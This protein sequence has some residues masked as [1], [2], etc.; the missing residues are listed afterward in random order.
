MNSQINNTMEPTDNMS[1]KDKATRSEHRSYDTVRD[2]LNCNLVYE[3]LSCLIKNPQYYIQLKTNIK[4]NKD[5]KEQKDTKKISGGEI[6]TKLKLLID[7]NILE[8]LIINP[9]RIRKGYAITAYGLNAIEINL[10]ILQWGVT[11][12]INMRGTEDKSL[13]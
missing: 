13:W 4:I 5:I 6:S 12:E 10:P 2:L 8:K 7:N 1:E 9:L 3:I 11:H